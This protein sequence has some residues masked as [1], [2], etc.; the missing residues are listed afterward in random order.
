MSF[1]SHQ[2]EEPDNPT[3]AGAFSRWN[4]HTGAIENFDIPTLNG[5][6]LNAFF[7]GNENQLLLVFWDGIHNETSNMAAYDIEN[8]T[9]RK[10]CEDVYRPGNDSRISYADGRV[11]YWQNKDRLR[12]L[13]V[14]TG[15]ELLTKRF[16]TDYYMPEHPSRKCFLVG[17]KFFFTL[18]DLSCFDLAN[19]TSI[20]LNGATPFTEQPPVLFEN[21]VYFLL[22]NSSQEE[23]KLVSADPESPDAPV[24]VHFRKK[25]GTG[26]VTG[27]LVSRAPYIIYYSYI[28]ESM[29]VYDL[30][31][32]QEKKV[33]SRDV[34]YLANVQ[35]VGDYL[36]YRLYHDEPILRYDLSTPNCAPI[37]I[38]HEGEIILKMTTV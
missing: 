32:K 28:H 2:H 31:T 5:E 16:T 12:I 27:S 30:R 17:N 7:A 13:D 8:G 18:E 36:Y 25:V 6:Y 15:K 35:I 9:Y 33:F 20:K 22:R 11:A 14:N 21:S 3:S 23:I 10:M 4:K 29:Y 26:H 37:A 19:G 38:G 1:R 24:K 34:N